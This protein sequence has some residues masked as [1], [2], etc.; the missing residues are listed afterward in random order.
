[1]LVRAFNMPLA[2]HTCIKLSI[3][4]SVFSIIAVGS[5]PPLGKVWKPV[6]YLIFEQWR[7]RL[8]LKPRMA[9]DRPRLIRT[10]EHIRRVHLST[11]NTY[12][13][14]GSTALAAEA[15]PKRTPKYPLRMV[16]EIP[17]DGP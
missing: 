2:I 11:K 3:N 17:L 15:G 6:Y 7:N 5:M 16:L 14:K 12:Q 4:F 13:L 9:G 10:A 8:R 1:M